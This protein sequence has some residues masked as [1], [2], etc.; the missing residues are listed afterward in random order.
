K[1]KG[2]PAPSP[3]FPTYLP[4]A[5]H[6]HRR[7]PLPRPPHP[8]AISSFP[9]IS[10]TVAASPAHLPL[11]L[12][13]LPPT[14]LLLPHLSSL[15]GRRLYCCPISPALAIGQRRLCCCP[16]SIYQ[17]SANP[18]PQPPLGAPHTDA[19]AS[20]LSLGCFF[21][22]RPSQFLPTSSSPPTH[23]RSTAAAR[24][25]QP[26]HLC[27][28]CRSLR[29]CSQPLPFSVSH[30]P[31]PPSSTTAAAAPSAA[32]LPAHSPFFPPCYSHRPAPP[33]PLPPLLLAATIG[34]TPLLSRCRNPHQTIAALFLPPLPA[35]HSPFL[36]C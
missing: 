20:F 3:F 36:P 10:T 24:C 11:L 33:Q 17:S 22:R 21:L 28:R 35:V 12:P 30:Y 6:S 34:R 7:Y 18:Q 19:I 9:C 13:H 4:P 15:I 1:R 2:L 23:P 16:I 29:S 14:L 32:A 27:S 25:S 31:L 5:K 26:C 8:S